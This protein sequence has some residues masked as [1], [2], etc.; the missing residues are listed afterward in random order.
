MPGDKQVE[1]TRGL[2]QGISKYDA[3]KKKDDNKKEDA[4]VRCGNQKGFSTQSRG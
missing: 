1:A 3:F 2:S 4:I